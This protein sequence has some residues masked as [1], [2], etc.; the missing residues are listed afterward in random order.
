MRVFCGKL[1]NLI[2]DIYP[3]ESPSG[4]KEDTVRDVT[5]RTVATRIRKKY[6]LLRTSALSDYNNP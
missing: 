2:F 3:P 1:R 5:G 6:G 4:A